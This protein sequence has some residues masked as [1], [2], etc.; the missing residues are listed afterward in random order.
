M[1]GKE[2]WWEFEIRVSSAMEGKKIDLEELFKKKRRVR[3]IIE[4]ALEREGFKVIAITDP[5][6]KITDEVPF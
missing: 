5:P 3:K 1:R 4:K 6:L 2:I